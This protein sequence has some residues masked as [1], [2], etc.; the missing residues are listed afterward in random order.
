M[1]DEYLEAITRLPPLA[2]FAVALI[3]FLVIP[4]MCRRVRLPGVVGL[5]A[6]GV[7]F[8]P[9]GL[10][11]APWHGEI[12]EFFAEIGKLLLM[13]F[14]GL[15]ID[16]PQFQRVRNR[17]LVF[18]LSSFRLPLAGG[19]GLGLAFGYN[20]LSSPLIGSVFLHRI[21]CW[22]TRSCRNWVWCATKRSL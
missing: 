22:V 4:P 14:A 15:E 18:G 17:S 21:R 11:V 19:F 7:L 16:L 20:W 8:G 1:F 13:L 3:V 10:H 6:A 5:L 2:R 9:S 12:A